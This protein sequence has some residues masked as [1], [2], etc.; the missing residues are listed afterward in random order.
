MR[1]F[2]CWFKKNPLL[3]KQTRP[4]RRKAQSLV[5]FALVL[6]I[7]LLVLL[8]IIE[9]GRLIFFYASVFGATREAARYG[10]AAGD[11][12]SGTPFYLDT[13]GIQA[14]ATRIGFFAGVK[15]G[16]VE[17][18][19]DLGPEDDR[20]VI[21]NPYPKDM[22]STWMRV[23]VRV[24]AYFNP[25]A[26]LVDFPG[27]PV[28]FTTARTIMRQIDVAGIPPTPTRMPT[29]T[30]SP[31]PIPPTATN[32]PTITLTP[33]DTNTPT[34]TRTPTI[35][36]T[37][38]ITSTPTITPTPTVTATPTETATITRT[39]TQTRTVTP[40]PFH[41]PELWT[42]GEGQASGNTLSLVIHYTPADTIPSIA[43]LQSIYIQWGGGANLN[44]IAFGADTIWT[45]PALSPL[46]TSV[47]IPGANLDIS[48]G[49]TKTLTLVF[50]TD[51]FVSQFILVTFTNTCQ[52]P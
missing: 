40:T 5:E 9:V 11:N 45:G 33:T 47:F 21:A 29:K 19:Y 20:H 37:S 25:A 36:L 41:C 30:N 50:S 31:T 44:S 12:P 16:D 3:N 2:T 6:P 10:T 32:T 8:G 38:T 13:A 51:S 1:S 52:V 24:T 43:T 22:P 46:S 49:S 35:T 23:V 42:I 14:A 17:V 4:P 18:W 15:P 27:I 39:P 28:S 34:I 7:L 26:P 48:S